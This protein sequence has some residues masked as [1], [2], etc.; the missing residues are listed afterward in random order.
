MTKS[1]VSERFS[2]HWYLRPV[3]FVSDLPA[4]LAFYIEKLGF[5]KRWHSAE[6]KGTVCQVNRGGCEIILGSVPSSGG[7][8]A[9][10]SVSCEHYPIA[11]K[12]S[13]V[14][15]DSN[16]VVGSFIDSALK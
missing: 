1:P 2:Q 6:G 8:F 9:H 16:G 10:Q 14:V 4:A 7:K 5:D 11:A 12:I 3:L 15:V 13:C